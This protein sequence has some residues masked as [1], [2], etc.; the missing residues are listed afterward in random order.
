MSLLIFIV[1][2]LVLLGLAIYGV[3]RLTMIA[4]DLRN[5][6]AVALILIAIVAV[7]QRAGLF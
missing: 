3:N 2:V 7:V 1:I 5:L 6:I 4:P